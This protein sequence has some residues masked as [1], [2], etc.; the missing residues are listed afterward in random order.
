MKP[1]MGDYVSVKRDYNNIKEIV[2]VKYVSEKNKRFT[3]ETKMGIEAYSFDDV[4]EIFTK[5]SHPEM[6]L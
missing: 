4:Y 3:A 6:Y 5:E 1:E 2:K